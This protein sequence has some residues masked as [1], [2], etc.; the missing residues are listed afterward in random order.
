MF[1]NFDCY[2]FLIVSEAL[3]KQCY[4]K[5]FVSPPIRQIGL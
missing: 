3:L 1:D 5:I 2:T 4:E